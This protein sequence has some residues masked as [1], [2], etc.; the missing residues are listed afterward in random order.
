MNRSTR[1][2]TSICLSLF[3]LLPAFRQE[4]HTHMHDPSEKL[5]RVNFVV[6]CSPAAQNEFNRATAL[7][8]SFWY[9]ESE[10]AFAAIA[11]SE[12]KCAMA[13]WGVA[14]TLYHPVWAPATSSELQRGW[15]A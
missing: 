10:K 8:H 15:A 4:M 2:F 12:P 1:L 3:I 9:E 7:L 5:G 14:M 11:M 13:H 6:H